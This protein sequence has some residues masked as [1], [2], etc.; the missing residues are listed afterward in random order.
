[1]RTLSALAA[2]VL[3][4]CSTPPV[5][6]PSAPQPPHPSVE[7]YLGHYSYSESSQHDGAKR[8]DHEE[9]DVTGEGKTLRATYKRSVT[10]LSSN[11]EPFACRQALYYRLQATYQLEGRLTSEGITLEETDV[12]T[13][14][15]PCERGTRPLVRYRGKRVD[16]G[17]LLRWHG[18]EQLLLRTSPAMATP[19]AHNSAVTGK[20]MW[21]NRLPLDSDQ[22]RVELE[23]WTLNEAADGAIKGSY[24]RLVTAYTQSGEPIPCAGAHRYSFRDRYS[25]SGTRRAAQI[26]IHEIRALEST[27]HPCL[28]TK[29][30]H[31]DSGTGHLMGDSLV[32]A[33]RGYHRQV[34]HRIPGAK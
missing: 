9:W 34:L 16:G 1:M 3:C 17:L 27:S 30:R 4:A 7:E 13:T 33:W 2:Y 11:A 26:E 20:W 5:Q 32:I 6:N 15:S 21:K 24:E 22:V 19:P 29:R 28:A 10:F 8:I 23:T 18:G 14:P 25:V 12:R 31:R